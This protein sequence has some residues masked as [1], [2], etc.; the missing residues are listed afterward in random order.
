MNGILKHIVY[1]VWVWLDEL[2]QSLEN[3]EIL[4]LLLMEQVESNLIL[5]ELHLVHCRFELIPLFFNHLFSLFDFLFLFLELLDLLVNL[6]FHHLEEVL[7]LNFKLV[8]N[9]SEALFKLVYFLIELL[10]DFHLKLIVEL[11]VHHD[12]LIMLVYLMDHFL[13]H[14]LHLIDL[15]RNLDN[16]MLHLCVLKDTLRAEHVSIV[17]TIEL[18]LFGWMDITESN[19]LLR[20]ALLTILTLIYGWWYTHWERSK[21]G[22]VDW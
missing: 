7:V 4:L 13:N 3:L 10:S 20:I 9:P 8:H 16:L 2:V 22:V 17:F 19:R 11:L 6:F 21:D 14:F 1:K 12:G 18:Y 5:I 15:W